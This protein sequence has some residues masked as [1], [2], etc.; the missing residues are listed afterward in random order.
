MKAPNKNSNALKI[1]DAKGLLE[2][3]G[4]VGDARS[5]ED[6]FFIFLSDAVGISIGFR[7]STPCNS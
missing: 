5:E 1:R 4:T 6:S 2:G 7:D 3:N